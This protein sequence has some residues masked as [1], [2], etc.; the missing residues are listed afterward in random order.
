MDGVALSWFQWMLRNSLIMSWSSL[1]Q[2][3]ESR[4]AP[5][6]YGD[7]KGTLFKL[8]QWGSVNQYLNEFERL[9]NLIIGL[10][11]SFLLNC[12][13]SGFTLELRREEDKLEDRCRIYLP[14][15]LN[16]PPQPPQTPPP[17]NILPALSPRP[18]PSPKT[19]VKRFIPNEMAHK[20]EPELCYNCDNKWNPTHRC[21]ARFF[22]LIADD[23]KA[24]LDPPP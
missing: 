8:T 23:E 14:R 11:P 15:P 20:R 17:T 13:I 5:T 16:N 24:T 10:P 2:A 18:L 1:L 12:F 3:L 7:P 21:K 4:F 22:L 6:F 19:Q 9:S